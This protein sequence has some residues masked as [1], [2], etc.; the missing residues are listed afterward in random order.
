MHCELTCMRTLYI[1]QQPTCT[2]EMVLSD[3]SM[4]VTRS[5]ACFVE[6][7]RCMLLLSGDTVTQALLLLLPP[8]SQHAAH[9]LASNSCCLFNPLSAPS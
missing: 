2:D 4:H 3:E 9:T 7:P 8:L 5:F 6:L 1:C